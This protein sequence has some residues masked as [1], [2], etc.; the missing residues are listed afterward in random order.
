M[1]G[2]VGREQSLGMVVVS[3]REARAGSLG[4]LQKRRRKRGAASEGVRGHA[5]QLGW[6][7]E[8][9][10]PA[11]RWLLRVKMA[12]WMRRDDKGGCLCLL[13]WSCG[14]LGGWGSL[15]GAALLT[16]A[17]QVPKYFGWS[18]DV[19]SQSRGKRAET[20]RGTSSSYLRAKHVKIL[21]SGTCACRI[22]Y[23]APASPSPHP[24]QRPFSKAG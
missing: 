20:A 18:A 15:G 11:R 17:A 5:R 23:S 7:V 12:G 2:R 6:W 13:A 22:R 10:R 4:L 14:S 3:A 1:S 24:V 21:S 16:D 8:D 19:R 9:G